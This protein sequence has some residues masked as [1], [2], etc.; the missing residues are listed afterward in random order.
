MLPET[1]GCC[2]RLKDAARDQGCRQRPRMP[3]ETQGEGPSL[4]HYAS[5]YWT[6]PTA[7]RGSHS[8]GSG[9]LGLPFRPGGLPIWC[10][11]RPRR[12]SPQILISPT[13]PVR[14]WRHD[15][16]SSALSPGHGNNGVT[17]RCKYDSSI[18]W[19]KR[20]QGFETSL[21]PPR[22]ATPH[23]TSVESTLQ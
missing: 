1:Q 4:H 22:N 8:L 18:N 15:S 13:Q 7:R 11:R 5:L 19:C 21:L 10:T 6:A 2:Q 14:G 16:S 12:P 20:Y 3:P 23:S 9:R 17:I